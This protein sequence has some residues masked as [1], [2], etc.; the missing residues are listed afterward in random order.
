MVEGNREK[1]ERGKVKIQG[2]RGKRKRKRSDPYNLFLDAA[3]SNLTTRNSI[4]GHHDMDEKLRER[5]SERERERQTD[6]QTDRQTET[7]SNT[8]TDRL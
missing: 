2:E 3:I 4:W 5:E 6:R 8:G 7:D 1:H